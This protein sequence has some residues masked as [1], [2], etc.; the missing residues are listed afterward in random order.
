[1]ARNLNDKLAVP[2][3]QGLIPGYAAVRESALS[4]GALA[5]SIG[6]S[7]PAIFAVAREGTDRI[8]EAMVEALRNSAG[9]EAESFV[10]RP[11]SGAKVVS[12]A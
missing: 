12:V 3:R 5:V 1:M 6:G 4:A 10:T 11:G 2:Y 8:Q 7:G 9:L